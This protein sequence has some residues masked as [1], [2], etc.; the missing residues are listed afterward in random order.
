MCG[1]LSIVSFE[2]T[3]QDDNN[4]DAR[5]RII[6]FYLFA[7]DTTFSYSNPFSLAFLLQSQFARPRGCQKGMQ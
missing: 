4:T 7:A 1:E 6:Y 5:E 3:E 2:S